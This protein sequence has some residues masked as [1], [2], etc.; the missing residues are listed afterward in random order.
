MPGAARRIAEIPAAPEALRRLVNR[1][2]GGRLAAM[3][4]RFTGN[5]LEASWETIARLADLSYRCTLCRRCA[6]SCAMW[7]SVVSSAA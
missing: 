7:S 5:D 4:G 6:Q 1:R 2:R 3:L